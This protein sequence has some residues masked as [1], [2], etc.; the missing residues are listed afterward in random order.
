M[1]GIRLLTSIL[2]LFCTTLAHADGDTKRVEL[3]RIVLSC[4]SEY[5]ASG[6]GA[7]LHGHLRAQSKEELEL[8]IMRFPL[9]VESHVCEALGVE[10]IPS[11]M[12][13]IATDVKRESWYKNECMFEIRIRTHGAQHLVAL[14]YN[15]TALYLFAE[16]RAQAIALEKSTREH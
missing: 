5:M 9:L 3:K 11:D 14:A 16:A 13:D 4:S 6:L 8:R 12:W 2:S 7:A 1:S 10:A 15:P